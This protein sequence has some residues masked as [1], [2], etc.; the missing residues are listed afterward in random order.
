MC[1]TCLQYFCCM[2][3]FNSFFYCSLNS[4]LE[5]K[6]FF[7]QLRHQTSNTACNLCFL[8]WATQLKCGDKTLAVG[9]RSLQ[10]RALFQ[11]SSQI[12]CYCHNVQFHAKS[13]F[14]LKVVFILFVNYKKH[15]ALYGVLL[16]SCFI[17]EAPVKLVFEVWTIL[18]YCPIASMILVISALVLFISFWGTQSM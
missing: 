7:H 14:S 17:I 10:N 12:I 3:Q 16:S 11:N 8:Y 9:V 15:Y 1:I 2:Y 6:K 5:R 4:L 18:T 13:S